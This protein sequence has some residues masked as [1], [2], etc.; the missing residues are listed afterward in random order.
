[1]LRFTLLLL[2]NCIFFTVFAQKSSSFYT[3]YTTDQG[4]PSTETYAVSQDKEGYLWFATDNGVCRFNGFEF[5][6]FGPLVA[7]SWGINCTGHSIDYVDY[8]K[9]FI[10]L[11]M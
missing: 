11:I 9:S 5:K 2:F 6:Q 7:H 4:L 10:N 1:M 8:H 3:N